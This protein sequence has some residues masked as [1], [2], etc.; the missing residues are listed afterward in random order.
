MDIEGLKKL[1]VSHLILM[2]LNDKEK[3]SLRKNA[4][5][6]LKKRIKHL[7][8]DYNDLLHLDD[9]VIKLRGFDIKNYLLSDD[10]DMQQLMETY[11]KY[12]NNKMYN[13]ELLFSEKHLCNDMCFGEP[14]FR[15]VV[16]KEIENINRRMSNLDCSKDYRKQRR[17]LEAVSDKL[18]KRQEYER[19]FFKGGF[20]NLLL[21]DL[22]CCGNEA[23]DQLDRFVIGEM[24]D[25]ASYYHGLNDDALNGLFGEY[26]RAL[27]F[28][29]KDSAKLS[30]Q[31]KYLLYQVGSGYEVNYESDA[32]KG[33]I[34]EKKQKNDKK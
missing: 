30:S 31:K 14:F 15:K 26:L 28:A 4:E 24:L 8:W 2:I 20:K 6:E 11:F 13:N 10:V 23:I 16:D 27:H 19:E 9:H 3:D 34:L 7:G 5:I 22:I 1:S 18:K 32:F 21:E 17:I 25:Y 29:Q 33:P 12:A